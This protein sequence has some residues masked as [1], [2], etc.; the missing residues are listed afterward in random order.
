MQA[1]VI[2]AKAG[3]Q[4]IISM[5]ATIKVSNAQDCLALLSRAKGGY[6]LDPGFHRGDGF[7]F[8][9]ISESCRLSAK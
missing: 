1:V 3:I 7:E 9:I 5:M 2:P 8:D 6:W 4:F